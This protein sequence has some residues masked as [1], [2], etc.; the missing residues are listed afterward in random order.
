MLGLSKTLA[1]IKDRLP[2]LIAR[3]RPT[4]G[5]PSKGAESD[6]PISKRNKKRENDPKA[7]AMAKTQILPGLPTVK[8]MSAH[9]R[10]PITGPTQRLTIVKVV[11]DGGDV[12]DSSKSKT[13][14]ESLSRSPLLVEF[15]GSGAIAVAPSP[16]VRA[17]LIGKTIA[18][19]NAV[20]GATTTA[21]V[22]LR[23]GPTGFANYG[24]VR[25][26]KKKKKKKKKR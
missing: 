5:G 19:G 7:K 22:G 24:N 2:S 17:D 3:T 11:K 10:R 25:R 15:V 4:V 8:S 9:G 21:N 12:E 1:A 26:K 6:A 13:K 20:D 16:H 14:L 18:G 23:S